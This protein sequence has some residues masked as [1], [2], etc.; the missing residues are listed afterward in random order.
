MQLGVVGGFARLHQARVILLA[1]PARV[2]VLLGREE[3]LALA[4]QHDQRASAAG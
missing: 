3:R 1:R 4:R 2:L